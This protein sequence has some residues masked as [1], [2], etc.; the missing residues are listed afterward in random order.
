MRTN[1]EHFLAMES[2]AKKM[3]TRASAEDLVD[4]LP[5]LQLAEEMLDAA[6][7][8][9]DFDYEDYSWYEDGLIGMWRQYY[10]LLAR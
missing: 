1:S 7:R 3:L 6:E 5:I 9:G 2:L 8:T 4:V 10:A